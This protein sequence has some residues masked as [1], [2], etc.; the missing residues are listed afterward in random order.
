VP[1]RRRRLHC[2][3]HQVTAS[4]SGQFA[5]GYAGSIAVPLLIRF[6]DHGRQLALAFGSSL[7]QF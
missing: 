7:D 2:A 1:K 5:S 3:Q 6:D 4:N